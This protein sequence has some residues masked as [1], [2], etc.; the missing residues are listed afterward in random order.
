MMTLLLSAFEV[1]NPRLPY[2]QAWEQLTDVA[3]YPIWAAAVAAKAQYVISDNT[4]DYPP[5]QPDGRHIYQGIEYISGR[6]FLIMLL[7]D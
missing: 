2:P 4:S 6:D 1:V 7:P 5:R 3:D